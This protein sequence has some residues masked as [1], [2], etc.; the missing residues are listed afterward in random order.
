VHHLLLLGEAARALSSEFRERH[1][2]VPWAQVVGLRNILVHQYFNVD[3]REIR[4][5]VERDLPAL[6]T[7][8]DSIGRA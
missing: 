3:P 1:P 7:V 4:A 8:L 5:I 6:R 2:A